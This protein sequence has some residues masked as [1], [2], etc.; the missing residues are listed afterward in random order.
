VF[1]SGDFLI[2]VAGDKKT[3]HS[4]SNSRLITA[5]FSLLRDY[6][7]RNSSLNYGKDSS[8]VA[9][10]KFKGSP[11]VLDREFAKDTVLLILP[12]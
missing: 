9:V 1:L 5:R 12:T 2:F 7:K 6:A 10:E 3:K 11:D 8:T 4:D